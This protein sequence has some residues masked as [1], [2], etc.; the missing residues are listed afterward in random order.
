MEF[1]AEPARLIRSVL[2]FRKASG[3]FSSVANWGVSSRLID[4]VCNGIK[5]DRPRYCDG[6]PAGSCVENMGHRSSSD[7]DWRGQCNSNKEWIIVRRH[8]T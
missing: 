3:K 4:W 8:C 5:L 2:H 1:V 6:Q 7:R